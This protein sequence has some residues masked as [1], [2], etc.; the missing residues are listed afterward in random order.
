MT[1]SQAT[2]RADED[3][4]DFS[5]LDFTQPAVINQFFDFGLKRAE[6]LRHQEPQLHT[7]SLATLLNMAV[8]DLWQ[9]LLE[10]GYSGQWQ[11]QYLQWNPV[12]HADGETVHYQAWEYP[13][14]KSQSR[15]EQAQ[16]IQ[17]YKSQVLT[18]SN[19][20]F[21]SEN[22]TFKKLAAQYRDWIPQQRQKL[23]AA[24]RHNS[25]LSLETILDEPGDQLE[26]ASLR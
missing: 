19:S 10:W 1:H 15:E 20:I 13:F 3:L 16:A 6:V 22:D 2:N 8:N 12:I 7:K 11:R 21:E 4:A 24:V 14:R 23:E 25:T 17:H 5:T 9:A 26:S 18:F